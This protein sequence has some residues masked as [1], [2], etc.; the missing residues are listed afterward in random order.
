MIYLF[1]GE[2]DFYLKSDKNTREVTN[3]FNEYKKIRENRDITLHYI[4]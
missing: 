2:H 4:E 3:V 1:V